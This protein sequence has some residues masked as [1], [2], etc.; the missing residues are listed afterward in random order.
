M[1]WESILSSIALTINWK[2][3][4]LLVSQPPTSTRAV[5]IACQVRRICKISHIA[6]FTFSHLPCFFSCLRSSTIEIA[7]RNL[8]R[9]AWGDSISV[10]DSN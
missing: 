8:L 6:R 4:L 9:L 5:I 2:L 3:E 10:I 7:G 1:F